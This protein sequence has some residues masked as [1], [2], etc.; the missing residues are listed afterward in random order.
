MKR[1][2]KKILSVFFVLGILL[3][4]SRLYA[5][6]S[7]SSLK[8]LWQKEYDFK[9]G[10]S[11]STGSAIFDEITN[12]LLVAGTSFQPIDKSNG[13]IWLWE[14]DPNGNLDRKTIL[15]DDI[16]KEETSI[17]TASD[18]LKG[19]SVS[20][21]RNISIMELSNDTAK[22]SAIKINQ[23]ANKEFISTA[24]PVVMKDSTSK[25][26][27]HIFKTIH[28]EDDSI[29]NIGSGEGGALA[30]KFDSE[31][32]E[33]WSKVYNLSNSE[34]LIDGI[35][36][37]N[38]DGFAV[39]GRA[40]S[41]ET[42]SNDIFVLLCD[43]QGE[44]VTKDF[45]PGNPLQL[46]R[47]CQLSSGNFIVAYSVSREVMKLMDVNIRVYTPDLKMLW[48]RAAIRYDKGTFSIAPLPNEGF[49]L[50]SKKH[51]PETLEV[52]EYDK[53]GNETNTISMSQSIGSRFIN[54]ACIKNKVFL[55]FETSYKDRKPTKVKII[56]LES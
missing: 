13:K 18:F 15:K 11:Y 24:Q 4:A 37:G 23:G 8:I 30:T 51:R 43:A 34:S 42:P 9:D 38:K 19:L 17:D 16:S 46:P 47:I 32:R 14:L 3:N 49:V 2:I 20:K 21:N 48:E 12:T 7:N 27:L 52:Y 54:I 53:N 44:I 22:W 28:F 29:L 55:I 25:R 36:T 41:Q 5:E 10:L 50:V 40:P 56:A 31:G 26:V 39:V 6:D 1:I 45:F 35:A 33:I